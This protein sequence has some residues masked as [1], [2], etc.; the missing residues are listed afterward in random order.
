VS[1]GTDLLYRDDPYLLEFETTVLER[2]QHQGRP[3]VVLDRTAFYAEA[4]KLLAQPRTPEE[5]IVA[6]CGSDRIEGLPQALE[7]ATRRVRGSPASS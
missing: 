6:L 5:P 7:A 4:R 1:A 3:A 2:R